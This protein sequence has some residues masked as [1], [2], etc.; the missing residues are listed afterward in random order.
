MLKAFFVVLLTKKNNRPIIGRCRLSN[1]RYR[2]SAGNRC[3]SSWQSV[4]LSTCVL[5]VSQWSSTVRRRIIH[6]LPVPKNICP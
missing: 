5:V 1:G 2:L 6:V 3:S 4:M